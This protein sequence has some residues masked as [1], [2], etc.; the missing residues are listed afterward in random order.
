MRLSLPMLLLALAAA[1]PAAAPA[2][3]SDEHAAAIAR[4]EGELSALDNDPSLAELGLVARMQARDAIAAAREARRRDRDH[5]VLLAELRIRTARAAAQVD[6][7]GQQSAQL[8]RERDEILL[9]SSRR[10]A[11]AARREAQRL[12]LLAM[13]REEM[14]E[15]QAAQEAATQAAELELASARTEQ[16]RKLAQAR[17]R[18]ADLARREAELAAAIAADDIVDAAPPPVR[19][20]GGR[21]IYTLDGAAFASGSASLTAAAQASLREL[22]ATL[23]GGEGRITVEGHT[24]GQGEAAANQA[25]SLRRAEAV[26]RA[27]EDAGLPAARLAAIGRGESDPVADDATADGRARNRRVEIIVE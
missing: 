21:D 2:A 9:E 23:R 5:T 26:R 1:F 12:Q 4:L 16:A 27:L 25:L 20:D 18:E 22:A 11:A 6:L 14:A 3:S 19:R 13:A 17:S 15:R 24:D 7:L 10:E 8:D